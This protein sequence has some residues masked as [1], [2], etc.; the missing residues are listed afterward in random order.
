MAGVTA[1][2]PTHENILS[3][4]HKGARGNSCGISCPPF[5][6]GFEIDYSEHRRHTVY[7]HKLRQGSDASYSVGAK[8]WHQPLKREILQCKHW[9]C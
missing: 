8:F 9:I 4:V 3:L 6:S 5:L 7:H 1:A 2:Q